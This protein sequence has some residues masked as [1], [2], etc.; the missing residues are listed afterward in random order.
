M[1]IKLD[2]R[3]FSQ[4]RPRMLTRYLF[5][6]ANLVINLLKSTCMYAMSLR[7]EIMPRRSRNFWL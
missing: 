3:H 4:G 6:V 7:R 2:V 5:A 1:V